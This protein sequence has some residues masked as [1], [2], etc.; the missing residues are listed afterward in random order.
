MDAVLEANLMRRLCVGDILKRTALNKPNQ[1]AIVY[2]YGGEV[3]GRVTYA[4]LDRRANRFANALL[5][6]GVKKGDRVAILSYNCIQYAVFIAA[7]AKMGA[8]ITPLNYALKAREIQPLIR[9]AGPVMFV[10]EDDMVAT[11]REIETELPSVRHFVMI[12]LNGR[13][14]LPAGWLDFDELCSD[15]HSG[16]EP[17]VAITGDDVLTLMYTSGTEAMPK[18][19][20]NSHA[21]WHASIM[22]M[23]LDFGPIILPDDTGLGVVPLFHVAGH[24]ALLTAYAYGTRMAMLHRP[25]PPVVMKV[26]ETGEITSA[27][28]SPTVMANIVNMP[29]GED[30]IRRLFGTLRWVNLYG[31]PT[32]EAMMRK[33][34]GLLPKAYF[35]NYY[36]QSEVTPLGTTL[37]S[38]DMLRKMKEASERFGGAEA[39]GQSHA[40][41]EM[42]VVDGDDREVPP[43]TMGEMAVRSPSVM[44]GYYKEEQ[45][46]RETFRN[47]WHHTGDLAVMDEERYYYFMDRKKDMIKTGA[48]NVSSVE[49]EGW[50]AKHPKVAEC[51]VVGLFHAR[52]VEA[53]TAFVVPAA[54]QKVDEAEIL[55]HC[56]EGLAGYKCPKKVVVLEAL[57]K[58]PSG[59]ILKRDLK[60]DYR[61][62][63]GQ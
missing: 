39:I 5:E 17:A 10:A 36:G 34:M 37:K 23:A 59:K 1:E 57:P 44:L 30:L 2:Y 40:M 60:R 4:E 20:M 49:V 52:W 18:G 51:A 55:G 6:M 26:F 35:Q 9:H 58:L 45:K 31:S 22:N 7:L 32:T 33:I 16:E 46:T 15:R 3:R 43:G 38:P 61:D 24:I 14:A 48:E 63:Y 41:V 8:W 42:K 29:G 27:N 19:V 62:I 50:V 11:V 56:R 53:V 21:N 47:G 13:T 12:D 28:I 25:D 54:G